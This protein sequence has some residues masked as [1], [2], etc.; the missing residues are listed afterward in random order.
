[1]GRYAYFVGSCLPTFRDILCLSTHRM[2]TLADATDR[3]S[4]SLVTYQ[5]TLRNNTKRATT[6]QL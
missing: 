1:M 4:L 5:H 6:S 2:L 3:L